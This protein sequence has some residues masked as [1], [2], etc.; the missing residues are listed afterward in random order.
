MGSAALLVDDLEFS[1]DRAG[2]RVLSIPRFEVGRG[3][4]VLL[5]GASGCGKSTLLH[6]VAGLID[7][8]RGRVRIDGRDIHQLKGGD[9]DRFRGRSIGMVFQTHNLLQGFTSVENV[10][11]PMHFAGSESPG[12]QRSRAKELLGRLGI[13][14]V[15]AMVETLSV[16]QQQRVAV[17]RALACGPALVLGDEPTA[18][19]DPD[20]AASAIALLHEA[21]RDQGAALLCVSHDP[22]LGAGFDRSVSFD[23]IMSGGSAQGVAVGGGVG[24]GA[25]GVLRG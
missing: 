5:R 22:A 23:E 1:Y 8:V 9:R 20:N 16:G 21:C 25:E 6:V 14:R 17:A 24:D 7:P 19:L 10:M 13:D 3:E 4:L 2:P 11:M 15:D 18:S 12:E